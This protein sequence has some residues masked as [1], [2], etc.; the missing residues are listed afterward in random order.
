MAARWR[1]HYQRS[2]EHLDMRY[3]QDA[4]V[5]RLTGFNEVRERDGPGSPPRDARN[6]QGRPMGIPPVLKLMDDWR[7]RRSEGGQ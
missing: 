2:S 7:R 3:E 4:P 5:R 6:R 1:T